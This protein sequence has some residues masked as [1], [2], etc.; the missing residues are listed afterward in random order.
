MAIIVDFQLLLNILHKTNEINWGFID[1]AE[2]EVICI[3]YILE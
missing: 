2:S 3:L 1:K